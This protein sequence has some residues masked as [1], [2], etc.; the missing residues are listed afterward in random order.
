[1]ATMAGVDRGR[2]QKEPRR[3]VEASYIPISLAAASVHLQVKPTEAEIGA[4]GWWWQAAWH[5][6]PE[7]AEDAFCR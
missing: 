2:W 4:H 3:V 6:Q 5:M 1:M 7:I